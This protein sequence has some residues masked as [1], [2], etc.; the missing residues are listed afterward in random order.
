MDDMRAVLDAIGCQT[1][2][3][4]MGADECSAMAALFAATYPDRVTALVLASPHRPTD[5][6]RRSPVGADCRRG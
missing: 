2:W 5:L 6:D 1:S 4:V 3:A